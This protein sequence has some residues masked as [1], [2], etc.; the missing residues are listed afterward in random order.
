MTEKCVLEQKIDELEETCKLKESCIAS[1]KQ[2][3]VEYKHIIILLRKELYEAQAAITELFS[4][5]AKVDQ[6]QCSAQ[7]EAL[8]QQLGKPN[9]LVAASDVAMVGI[10]VGEYSNKHVVT[11]LETESGVEIEMCLIFSRTVTR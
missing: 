7:I 9:A 11:A 10:N 8:E 3:E 6:S 1:L 2:R 5:H 4:K